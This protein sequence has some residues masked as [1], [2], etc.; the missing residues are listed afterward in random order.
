MDTESFVQNVEH[1]CNLKGE[2]P[3]IACKN[4][5]AGKDMI[6]NLKRGSF[7]S[8][9]K[10]QLLAEYLGCNVSDLLGET[11]GAL[12]TVPDSTTEQFLK[13]FASLD[14]KAQNEIVAEMLKR[15]K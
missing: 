10:V 15:K 13:L 12:P 7:P 6:S 8:I 11:P 14:D 9:V 5:G 1:W 4:S 2:P 3:T